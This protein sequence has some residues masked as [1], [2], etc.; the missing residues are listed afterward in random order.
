MDASAKR[1]ML[2][3]WGTK[4]PDAGPDFQIPQGVDLIG[5][6]A[7]AFG[8]IAKL[9]IPADAKRTASM[10]KPK[11]CR[12][13]YVIPLEFDYSHTRNAALYRETAFCHVAGYRWK[14]RYRLGEPT[15]ADSYNGDVMLYETNGIHFFIDRDDACSYARDYA[16]YWTEGMVP[17]LKMLC[18]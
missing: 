14:T 9:L 16:C 18:G 6:K 17:I 1:G 10:V 4:A 13:E 3:V 11:R 12:A 5:W 8:I 7:L 2:I 15:R